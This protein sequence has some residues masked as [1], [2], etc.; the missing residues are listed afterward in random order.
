MSPANAIDMLREDHRQVKVMFDR[1]EAGDETTRDRV[2]HDIIHSITTHS[3]VEETVLYPFIRAEVP[4]GDKLM[5]EAEQEHQE[6]RDAIERLSALDAGDPEFEQSFRTL[7]EAVEHHVEEEEQEVF[8]KV[9][10]VADETKMAE[11]GQRL[12]QAKA[13]S[14]RPPFDSPETGT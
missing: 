5:D 11:L 1:F 3:R 9:S 14:S 7:R 10:D 4:D 13:M 2:L 6:A 12:A 8:P